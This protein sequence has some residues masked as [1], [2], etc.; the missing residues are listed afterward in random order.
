[1][2]AAGEGPAAAGAAAAGAGPE[3]KLNNVLG[4]VAAQGYIDEMDPAIRTLSPGART[5][6]LLGMVNAK[7]MYRIEYGIHTD[8]PK[9][10]KE[11]IS[12]GIHPDTILETGLRVLPLLH[13]AIEN[14]KYN[15]ANTLLSKG[16]NVNLIAGRE[17][18][19]MRAVRKSNYR[20]V[21]LLLGYGADAA[22]LTSDNQSSLYQALLHDDPRMLDLLLENGA[23]SIVNVPITR[24]IQGRMYEVPLIMAAVDGCKQCVLSLIRAGADLNQKGL[25]FPKSG[26]SISGWRTAEQF[27]TQLVEH[28]RQLLHLASQ[29]QS[30]IT[31][32]HRQ[33]IKVYN[34]II[35]ILAE[36]AASQGGGGRRR[37]KTRGKRKVR[38]G[39]RKH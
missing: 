12:F 7:R 14:S 30:E 31:N 38:K 4:I 23:S 33:K 29:A 19:L 32:S 25:A 15:A 11:E 9:I 34:E 5:N 10:I 16:A 37:R 28:Y 39:T 18:P 21:N 2:Y 26:V 27:C 36:A 24:G 8:N 13:F 1:M 17:T 3:T 22:L 6:Y 35:L 20:M